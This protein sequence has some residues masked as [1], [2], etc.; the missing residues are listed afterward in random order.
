MVVRMR[1]THAHT[2]NRRSHHALSAQNLS[3]EKG[4]P[5]MRHRVSP[6]TGTYRGKDVSSVQKKLNK[7][8]A[9]QK[10]RAEMRGEAEKK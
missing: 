10:A 1:H 8:V 4:A 2:R 6:T 5:H 9:K 3:S 7:T